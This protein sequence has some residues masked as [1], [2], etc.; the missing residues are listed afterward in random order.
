MK[1]NII[2][3]PNERMQKAREF[4]Q[5]MEFEANEEINLIQYYFGESLNLTF[6]ELLDFAWEK[7]YNGVA[8]AVMKKSFVEMLE[9]R[10]NN[11]PLQKKQ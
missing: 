5:K 6:I 10:I 3:L 8:R 4:I 11:M 1:N 7:G 2:Q 9:E